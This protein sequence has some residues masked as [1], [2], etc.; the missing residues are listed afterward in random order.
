MEQQRRLPV[1][2]E[3]LPGGGVDFRVWA[4]RRKKVSVVIE[5]T[6]GRDSKSQA[7]EL[8]EEPG[9]YFSGVAQM[10]GDGT[11]YRFKLD[12]DDNLYPDPASRFQPEGPHGPSQV[13]NPNNFKWSDTELRGLHIE[14]QVIYEMHIGTFTKEGTWRAAM[15]ELRE[16]AE[17]G[18][19]VI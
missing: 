17:A 15:G 2:A 6:S 18:I 12:D 5:S 9:G 16:L 1:G 4:P 3:L 7:V 14:G 19:T 13:I 10:A 8:S 11:L